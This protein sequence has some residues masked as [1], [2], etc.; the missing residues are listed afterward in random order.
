MEGISEE[1]LEFYRRDLDLDDQLNKKKKYLEEK[2][3]DI[4][5][6]ISNSAISYNR[7]ISELRV[8]VLALKKTIKELEDIRPFIHQ[9]KNTRTELPVETKEE[10]WEKLRGKRGGSKLT[11]KKIERLLIIYK[12][13]DKVPISKAISKLSI[14]RNTYYRVINLDYA[15]EKTRDRI[16]KIATDLD[17]VLPEKK[18]V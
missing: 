11:D 10:R 14:T 16:R 18:R 7:E 5:K 6:K 1:E 12:N 8:E 13:S 15:Y 2:E 9:K 4:D 3:Q 17:I